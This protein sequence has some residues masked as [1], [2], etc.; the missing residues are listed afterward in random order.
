M[1]CP[2][3][4]FSARW[5]YLDPTGGWCLVKGWP[6]VLLGHLFNM[7]PVQKE[8]AADG[9]ALNTNQ[10]F[11]SKDKPGKDQQQYQGLC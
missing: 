5:A 8:L 10:I 7:K 9:F 4:D 11:Y 3:M 6:G 2:G 1:L